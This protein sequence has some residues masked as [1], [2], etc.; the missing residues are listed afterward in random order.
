M[1]TTQ[2]FLPDALSEFLYT[3]VSSYQRARLRDT[4]N[5]ADGIALRAG[6]T[7]LGAV[8]EEGR[9]YV[10]LL[11]LV[12]DPATRP[13]TERP[14]PPGSGPMPAGGVRPMRPRTPEGLARIRALVP[15]RTEG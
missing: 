3:Q 15:P 10:A 4:L 11:T 12:V 6:D 14:P 9:R 1:L 2:F 8:R 5:S 7:V 13:V